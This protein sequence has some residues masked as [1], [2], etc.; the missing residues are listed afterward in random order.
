MTRP[1]GGVPILLVYLQPDLGTAIIMVV[2][3]VVML[4]I[5][6]VPPRFLVLLAFLG[7]VVAFVAVI[8]GVLQHCHDHAAL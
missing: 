4:A 3:L 2:I 8:A 7:G 1:K 6:G 5:A